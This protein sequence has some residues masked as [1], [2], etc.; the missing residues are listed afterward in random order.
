MTRWWKQPIPELSSNFGLQYI[1][2]TTRISAFIVI[3]VLDD[4][5][6][7]NLIRISTEPWSMH[8]QQFTLVLSGIHTSRS[9]ASPF[10]CSFVFIYANFFALGYRPTRHGRRRWGVSCSMVLHVRE[11]ED[12]D[13]KQRKNRKRRLWV[14]EITRRS[15]L[16][17]YYT[18]VYELCSDPERFVIFLRQRLNSTWCLG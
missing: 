13:R 10:C 1:K 15:E 4:F 17:E 18:M 16:G 12:R 9:T 2:W 8:V 6:R 7:A 14:H 11:K 3:V 5:H